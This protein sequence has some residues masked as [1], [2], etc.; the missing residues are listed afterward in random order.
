MSAYLSTSEPQ[1]SAMPLRACF[2]YERLYVDAYVDAYMSGYFG[3][4]ET[5]ALKEVPRMPISVRHV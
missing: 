3:T 4:Y 1:M 5:H 2:I